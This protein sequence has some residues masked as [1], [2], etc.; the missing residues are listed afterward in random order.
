MQPLSAIPRELLR[1]TRGLLFDLDDTFLDH[2]RLLPEALTALYRLHAAGVELY[3]VTGRPASWGSLI[4]HQWPIDGAITENGAIAYRRDAG[5][6]RRFDRLTLEE[7]AA[8][9]VAVRSIA[10]ELR[11][12]HP[13]L[14]LADDVAGRS[15]DVTFD[16]GEYRRVAP[17]VVARARQSARA[18]GA[19]TTLSSVHLHVSLDRAD[20]A[21][22]AVELL[23]SVT[24]MP[25]V[26][27]LRSYA[28]IGDSENDAACFAAFRLT[29]GVRNLSGRPTVPP[30]FLTSGERAAG[31]AEAAEL[32]L[33]RST[34]LR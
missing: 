33:A 15:S 26:R 30:R 16:I 29:L 20:K 27:I 23:R 3:A 2:G 24:G 25:A 5:R 12:Q 22:G 1:D 7:R 32:L 14:E 10:D 6:V 28:F 34:E 11:R 19:T 13:E 21:S 17:E 18:L 31:F 4:T 9:R 8:R